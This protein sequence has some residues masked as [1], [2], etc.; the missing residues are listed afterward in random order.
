M[1]YM[2]LIVEDPTQRS[3]RTEDEGRAVY[4]RMLSY[5]DELQA[6]GLLIGAESLQSQD[7][8]TR[9]QVRGGKSV[10]VDGPFTEL[11]EMVGGFFMLAVESKEEAIEI[12]KKCPAAE[13][14]TIEVRALAPCYE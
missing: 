9:V 1:P 3:T 2:L 5:V 6:R 10:L 12:A 4:G 13:W 7:R 8:A 11:K 14:C